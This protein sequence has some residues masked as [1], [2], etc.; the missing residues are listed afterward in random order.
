MFARKRHDQARLGAL[1]AP[2]AQTG[3]LR[4]SILCSVVAL[5]F[6]LAIA[7]NTNLLAPPLLALLLTASVIAVMMSLRRRANPVRA[8]AMR[9]NDGGEILNGAADTGIVGETLFAASPVPGLLV[10]GQFLEIIA[11]NPAAAVLYGCRL[12]EILG[13]QFAQLQHSASALDDASGSPPVAGL[14]RHRRANGSAIWV[15]LDVQS[16]QRNGRPVW[17]VVVTDVTARL[18]QASDLEISER[19]ARELIELSM[20]IVFT[21][22]LAGTLQMTNPAFTRA[23]GYS[24]EELAGRKLSELIVPRQHNAFVAYLLEVTRNGKDSGAVHML[25]RD[26]SEQVWEFRNRLRTVANESQQVICCA[27]DITDRSRIERRLLEE[28]RKDP[29]TGCYNRSHLAAFQ[30]DARPGASWACVVIDIDQLKRYN[31]A[32]GHRSGD[33]AIVRM[34][35]FLERMVRKDDSIVR[36]GGDEFVILLQNCDKATLESFAT[37]LQAAQSTQETIPFSFGLSMRKGD[38]E[39]E[40]TIHRADRQMIERRTIESSSIRIDAPRERKRPDVRRSVIRIHDRRET[41]E[42]A[43]EFTH[44]QKIRAAIGDLDV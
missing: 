28:S 37:R 11:A 38:E 36:L 34:A 22:D 42:P 16:I 43:P 2:P 8:L 41:L 32:Y 31:D 1:I 24:A 6:I 39:L 18:Q 20:G 44:A 5:A 26:G 35:R 21:H 27:I 3:T 23:L 7:T 17:L 12:D 15:E 29:L 14:T 4:L 40:D 30:V 9:S 13:S 33:Q 19:N 10:D 25:S